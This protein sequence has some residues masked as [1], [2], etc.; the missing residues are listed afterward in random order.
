[1]QIL[2][3]ETVGGAHG[4]GQKLRASRPYCAGR[5]QPMRNLGT[6]SSL[7]GPW[8]GWVHLRVDGPPGANG[9]VTALEAQAVALRHR[10]G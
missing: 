2:D 5:T 1:M 8:P 4:P 6:G 10:C 7:R 3:G 9:E